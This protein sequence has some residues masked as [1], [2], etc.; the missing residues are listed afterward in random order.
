MLGAHAGTYL[1]K[2]NQVTI[3]KMGVLFPDIIIV[4]LI[5][6]KNFFT[7]LLSAYQIIKKNFNKKYST[8]K[9]PNDK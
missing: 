2:I 7:T 1:M 9:V 8:Y 4:D 6:L 3:V 5:A